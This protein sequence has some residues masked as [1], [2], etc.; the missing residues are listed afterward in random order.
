MLQ[1]HSIGPPVLDLIWRDLNR[2]DC[3]RLIVSVDKRR[4]V[5]RDQIARLDPIAS[6]NE[7]NILVVKRSDNGLRRIIVLSLVNATCRHNQVSEDMK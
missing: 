2:L 3:E 4:T 6:Q 1:L 5:Y 7:T